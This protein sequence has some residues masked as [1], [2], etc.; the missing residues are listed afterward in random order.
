MDPPGDHLPR[1]VQRFNPG[2]RALDRGGSQPVDYEQYGYD[3]AGNLT[4]LRKRDG[5]TLTYS[6]DVLNRITVKVVP[7]RADLTAAQTHDVYY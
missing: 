7:S 5:S 1:S 2:N 4:S 3:A 6:Y